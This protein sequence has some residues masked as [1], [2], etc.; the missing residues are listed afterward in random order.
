LW[1][2]F[3]VQFFSDASRV[4]L[5]CTDKGIEETMKQSNRRQLLQ[6]AGGSLGLASANGFLKKAL[7]S[8]QSRTPRVKI[9]QIG[10]GH[11]HA[12]KLSAYRQSNDYEVVGV[13]EPDTT[14]RKKVENTEPYRGLKWLTQEQLLNTPGLNAVL[15][16]TRIRDLLPTAENCV[17]AGMHVH[18]D[19]PAGTSLPHLRRVLDKAAKKKLLVQMGY[20][21][22]YNPAIILLRDF[23]KQGWLGEVFEV[24]TVMSK[25]VDAAARLEMAEYPGGIMFELGCHIIDLVVGI[26]GK[27]TKVTN[28]SQRIGTF[29][30]ALVDNMLSVLEY[31]KAIA[32]V[33]S[34]AMEVDG[35]D[36]RHIVVCG[37]QGTFHIQ[38]LDN[39]SAR[40]ALDS[41]HSTYKKGYQDVSFPKFVRYT[42]DAA[43]MALII[44]EMKATDFSYEHDLIVQSTV[45]ESCGLSTID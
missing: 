2:G 34:S 3:D 15:V 32:T 24:H 21:Y 43:D 36:R 7:S 5:F 8:N 10:V 18:I 27:P 40:I 29:K 26:L 23:L 19:K 4:P 44:R 13:V 1:N 12:T 20:M 31:P 14:L 33:K 28:H 41:P 42:Q 9:G 17:D 25:T 11:A 6:L 22:R 39:P 35:F 37:T 45:L 30:D 38:P 16:E